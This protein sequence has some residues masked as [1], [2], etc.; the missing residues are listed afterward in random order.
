MHMYKQPLECTQT[1]TMCED[2]TTTLRIGNVD[3]L[4]INRFRYILACDTITP[5]CFLIAHAHRAHSTF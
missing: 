3:L 2:I 5:S 4:D 1:Y